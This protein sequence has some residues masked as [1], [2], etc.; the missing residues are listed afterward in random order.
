MIIFVGG[1]GACLT[2]RPTCGST[3]RR[4]TRIQNK[5]D[6]HTSTS[7]K[8]CIILYYTILYYIILY[9]IVVCLAGG[10]AGDGVELVALPL[11]HQLGNVALDAVDRVLRCAS[12]VI[13]LLFFFFLLLLLFIVITIII[14]FDSIRVANIRDISMLVAINYVAIS[15]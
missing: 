6:A 1:H 5:H 10:A 8:P 11:L 3:T 2:A 9:Y 7:I 4:T 12:I 14:I 15:G 13:I